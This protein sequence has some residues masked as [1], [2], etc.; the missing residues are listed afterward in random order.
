MASAGAVPVFALGGQAIG[1]QLAG[2]RSD[3]AVPMRECVDLLVE[4]KHRSIVLICP[5]I[6][7]LPKLNLSAQVFVDRLKHHGIRADP[8]YNLPDWEHTPEG[9]NAVLKALFHTT[10]PTA[11]LVMDPEFVGPVLVF[12][13]ERGLR[14]PDDVSVVNIL[15]DPIQAFYRPALAHFQWPVHPHVKRVL[16]WVNA[17]ARGES[18]CKSKTTEP[19]FIPTASIGPKPTNL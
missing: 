8:H 18:D 14:V 17:L 12:L 4:H 15:P 5:P 1:L 10:R 19:I 11:L 16:Q 3:L 2:S 13:A 9:L 6:W 7:R